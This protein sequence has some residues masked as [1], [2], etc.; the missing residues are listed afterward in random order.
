MA[1][2]TIIVLGLY[3]L[4]IM[5]QPGVGVAGIAIPITTYILVLGDENWLLHHVG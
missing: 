2:H 3:R 4:H 1:T 5:R